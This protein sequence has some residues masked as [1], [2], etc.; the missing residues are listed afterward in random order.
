MYVTQVHNPHNAM[1]N[2]ASHLCF[3]L[4]NV[5][6]HNYSQPVTVRGVG[7]VVMSPLW[8][9]PVIYFLFPSHMTGPHG[10][11][12]NKGIHKL[13]KQ[14]CYPSWCCPGGLKLLEMIMENTAGERLSFKKGIPSW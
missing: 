12:S 4:T 2:Y 7:P 8:V 1:A 14:L 6:L 13:S 3:L 5:F 11:L 9:Q 10:Q